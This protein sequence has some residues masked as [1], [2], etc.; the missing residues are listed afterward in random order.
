M[1]GAEAQR[2]EARAAAHGAALTSGNGSGIERGGYANECNAGF[3][4]FEV[5]RAC[6]FL[7]RI[8]GTGKR[9]ASFVEVPDRGAD[10]LLPEV[11]GM[12]VG[13]V[14]EIEAEAPHVVEHRRICHCPCAA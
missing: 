8:A 1:N 10:A 5:A 2:I 14:E 3:P 4:G 11:A 9:H 6:G 13:S 7:K 12:V